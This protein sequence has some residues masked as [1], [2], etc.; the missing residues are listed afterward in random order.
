MKQPTPK[1]DPRTAPDI[2]AQVL[3]L[4][5]Q[6]KVV[7]I[8]EPDWEAFQPEQGT[9]GA[10]IGIFARFAELITDRLNRVPDKNFLAF[11]DLLGASLLPPTSARAPLTFSLTDGATGGAVVPA[12]TE[13]GALATE[14]EKEPAVFETENEIVITASRLRAA[15]TRDPAKDLYTNHVL[16]L[17]QSNEVQGQEAA[18]QGVSQIEHILYLAHDGIFNQR[19]ERTSL[20]L[21]R[22]ANL[23]VVWEIWGEETGEW[24]PL[25]GGEIKGNS[26]DLSKLNPPPTVI[27][28]IEKRWLRC[29]LLDKITSSAPP[30]AVSV[31]VFSATF[32]RS[33]SVV[34]NAF[35]NNFPVDTNR[36]FYPFG[37]SPKQGDT[38]YLKIDEE[39]AEPGCTVTLG[40]TLSVVGQA[41]TTQKPRNP[42]VVWEYW[43]GAGWATLAATDNTS[44]LTSPNSVVFTFPAKYALTRVNGVEGYWVRARLDSG[45]YGPE[46]SLTVVKSG[47]NYTYTSTPAAAPLISSMKISYN[48]N[49]TNQMPE[50][51]LAYN[52]F[53]YKDFTAENMSSAFIRAAFLRDAAGDANFLFFIDIA[54]LSFVPNSKIR[55]YIDVAGEIDPTDPPEIEWN[56]FSQDL[57]WPKLT[58]FDTTA[59]LTRAGFIEYLVPSNAQYLDYYALGAFLKHGKYIK[60]PVI[61][62]VKEGF[63]PFRA[64]EDDKPTFYLGFQPPPNLSRMPNDQINVYV[65]ATGEMDATARPQIEWQYSTGAGKTGWSSITVLDDTENFTRPGIVEFLAPPD[66][67]PR[68]EAGETLYWLRAVRMDGTYT[69]EPQISSLLLNTVMVRHATQIKNEILG[70]SD[71]SKNQKFRTS[72]VP[73]LEGQRLD[74]REIEK[75]SQM[76][77]DEIKRD[78]GEDAVTIVAD[79]EGQSLEVWVLWNQMPDFY[80]SGPQDRHYV[81]EYLTGEVRFGDGV[82][83]MIPPRASGNI[84]MTSYRTG[85][86]IRG[87]KPAGA[88]KELRT[89]LPYV[90]GA[91]NYVASSGGADAESYDSLVDRM[92]R[93]IRHGG[94]AVTYQDYEDL[95]MLASPEVARARSVRFYEKGSVG[96]VT[97]VIVPRTPDPKPVPSRELKR[98]VQEFINER[99]SPLVKLTVKSPK[100][101]DVNVTVDIAPASIEVAKTLSLEV[102][103]RLSDFLHPLTGGFD[104]EGWDFGRAPHESDLNYLIEAIAGVDH[105]RN[106][107]MTPVGTID[108][109]QCLIASGTL[110]VSC[111]FQA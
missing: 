7:L 80:G 69:S 37:E 33:N 57:G 78:A 72:L 51:V 38:L 10:L 19:G 11:L 76:G 97:L 74:V 83:G 66:F 36:G 92:P 107:I 104:G 49:L 35:T 109:E 61:S 3:D 45:S 25:V 53:K 42:S 24:V 14:G 48:I 105:I 71:A 67:A 22:Q 55:V 8:P 73:V 85:G 75:P 86:G 111:K 2:F 93:M 29:R 65:G 108:S 101:V 39:F 13:V 47:D 18:F 64:S 4:L 102:L 12:G 58:A 9:S 100:Y 103:E 89:S 81:L 56:Y 5:D 95:A 106:L 46:A 54:P 6:Q 1:I 70:S 94:C 52:D 98:R 82:S 27:N 77:R 79:D 34:E 63:A 31:M 99:K 91:T 20:T 26:I 16:L 17:P 87:N 84:R 30:P 21:T 88:I 23:N 62:S 15:F 50:I 59:A 90:E 110:A 60:K 44:N 41:P 96:K 40:L 68:P 43:D 28:G 32:G